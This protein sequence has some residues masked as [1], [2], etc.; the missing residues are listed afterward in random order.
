MQ[1]ID[2][3]APD[4]YRISIYVPKFDLQFNHFLIKDDE[5]LLFHTGYKGMFSEVHDAVKK[6]MNPSQIRWIGFS[7]FESDECGSLNQW[8]ELS[9]SAQ[10]VCTFLAASLNV[11]DFAIRPAYGMTSDETLDT[12]KYRFRFCPTAHLPHGWDAGVLFEETSRT[13]FCSDLFFHLGDVEPLTGSDIVGRARKA[14]LDFQSTPFSYSMPY[15][16]QTDRILRN[17]ASLKP[18]TLATMHG[19]SFTGDCGRAL[20]DLS[21]AIKET[22]GE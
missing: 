12:G 18:K 14:L 9:P 4:V 17:L 1:K 3:I 2:E 22:L 7:H 5:P 20:L 13:L 8:L 15:T 21:L 10:P 19:S 6:V 11:D 16:P